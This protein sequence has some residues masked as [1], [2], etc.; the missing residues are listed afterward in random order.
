[1]SCAVS[2]FIARSQKV[3]SDAIAIAVGKMNLLCSKCWVRS[4]SPG[5][6]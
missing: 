4:L 5:Q 1:M 3:F 2:G 6:L